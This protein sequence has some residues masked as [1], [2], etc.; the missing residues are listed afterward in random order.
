MKKIQRL[1]ADEALQSLQSRPEGLRQ[2]EAQ[3]RLTEFGRNVV[4]PYRG[5]P[6]LRR[7]LKE[8]THFFALILWV[9]AGLA[10]CAKWNEPG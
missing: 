6:I 7:L 2:A 1:T 10:F 8:F 3:R 5:E 9:A 4:E